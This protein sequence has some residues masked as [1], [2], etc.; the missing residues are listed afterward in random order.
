MGRW[1]QL[2]SR[3]F[4]Q[5]TDIIAEVDASDDGGSLA[6]R[7]TVPVADVDG[8]PA[9][10]DV[11]AIDLE[12]GRVRTHAGDK[13][14]SVEARRIVAAVVSEHPP[15]GT[16]AIRA[17][18][19]TIDQARL[20]DA[21]RSLRTIEAE[22]EHGG[23]VTETANTRAIKLAEKRPLQ[24]EFGVDFED[25]DTLSVTPQ[26]VSSD[27]KVRLDPSALRAPV[28]EVPKQR[29]GFR[30]APPPIVAEAPR[31]VRQGKTYYATPTA[32]PPDLV[33]FTEGRVLLQGDAVPFFLARQ[34]RQLNR[35]GKVVA[36]DAVKNAKV[37]TESLEPISVLDLD[38][39]GW[40]AVDV[41]FRGAGEIVTSDEMAL[42]PADTQYIRRGTTWIPI[43]RKAEQRLQETITQ[44]ERKFNARRDALGRLRVTP[45]QGDEMRRTLI[46]VAEID[47]GAAFQRFLAD[48]AGF[49]EIEPVPQPAGLNATMRP[50]QTDGFHWLAFLRKYFLNGV[51]A[52]DMGLGKSLMTLCL[53][54][55]AKEHPDAAIP[56][57]SL[58]I[59]PTSCVDNWMDE[60][61]KFA[62]GLDIRRY[63][64]NERAQ[65]LTGTPDVLITTYDT[66]R[67]DMGTL[68]RQPWDYVILDEAQKIKNPITET[69]KVARHLLARHRLAVTG[70]PIE[71]KLDELWAL[72]DFLMPGYLGSQAR[73]RRD[74]DGPITREK[75]V[76]VA[77][78]LKRKIAPFIL[79]RMKEQVATDLP[80]KLYVTRECKLTR[81]QET[82]YERIAGEGRQRVMEQAKAGNDVSLTMSILAS[83]TH[84]KQICCHPGLLDGTPEMMELHGRSGKFEAF[85][86]VLAERL[87]AGD[88][89]LVFSQ[90]AEM[91]KVIDR[92]LHERD[93]PSLYL[94][95]QTRNRQDLVRTFQADPNIKVFVL[96][97]RAA[98]FGITLTAA[99]SVI[100]YD[101]WW[102][103]AVENQATDRAY[104]IGQKR[105]VQVVQFQTVDT[106]EEKIDKLL[107]SKTQLFDDVIETDISSK[108]ISRNELIDLF[109]YSP[110]RDAGTEEGLPFVDDSLTAEAAYAR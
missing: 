18:V 92:Y 32:P 20:P 58:I 29:F 80:P 95:G 10:A 2:V 93:I 103:P 15:H 21:L 44:V 87:E 77:D 3:F 38:D 57:P 54:Q 25:E 64:G 110:L 37:S 34:L 83:L 30:P 70:T 40:L 104:R 72:F 69:A 67:R 99:S 78:E 71:N 88:K 60:A 75:N 45:S 85:K 96:S 19:V 61:A 47:E 105:S 59:C 74:Y 91:C 82:L 28:V 73:F 26:V 22:T 66:L 12:R 4:P 41:A 52:D 11:M 107:T 51:L 102:N 31:W 13:R 97:L 49:H 48:L 46:D 17:G 98:G 94:D 1:Q 63:M 81:E 84:L 7:L 16:Q 27:G 106:I 62:P 76:G 90:Y 50:Y 33:P 68:L 108:N 14:L 36:S 65:A 24:Y 5:E 9:L 89:V 35:N 55:H 23:A 8:I 39:E 86:E 53:L 43:D 56:A 42:L 101:R 79:R 100:H 6:V 109:T